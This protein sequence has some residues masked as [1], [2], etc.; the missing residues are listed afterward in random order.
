MKKLYFLSI[1]LISILSFAQ[2]ATVASGKNASGS[3]GSLSYTV[4]QIVYTTNSGT[5]GSLAQGVQQPFEISTLGTDEFPNVSLSA[6]PNPTSNALTLSLENY[7]T[8]NLNY[9]LFDINGRLIKS[10]KINGN[11]TQIDMAG[12][13][14]GTYLLII[15]DKSKKLKTFKIIKQ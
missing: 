1:T 7:D 10:N 15:N 2:Q 12:N 4:G 9:E 6:F 5:N 11:Q 8:T 14:T 13:A 3:G